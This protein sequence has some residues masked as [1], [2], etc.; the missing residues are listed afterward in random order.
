MFLLEQAETTGFIS[1]MY[2]KVDLTGLN[3]Y[4]LELVKSSF[5]GRMLIWV[6]SSWDFEKI[7]FVFESIV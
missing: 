3:Y 6:I 1:K 7:L 2:A 4:A 5:H